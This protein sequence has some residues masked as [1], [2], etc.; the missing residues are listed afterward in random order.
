MTRVKV[1]PGPARAPRRVK[2]E[3]SGVAVMLTRLALG[4]CIAT[5][6]ARATMLETIRLPQ[7]ERWALQA[8]RTPGAATSLVLDLAC[9]IPAL[10]VLTRL[11]IDPG[12][13]L[14]RSW[15]YV[16]M[17]LL[18]GWL[19]LS[20]LWASD[21]FAA[22]VSAANFCAALVLLWSVSQ[23][24]RSWMHLRLVSAFAFALLVILVA[25]GIYYRVVDYPDLQAN[26][27][28]N[29][30]KYLE[31]RQLTPGSFPARR[32]EHMVVNSKVMAFSVSA[33][34]Y[35]ALI[36]MT[37]LISVGIALQRRAHGDSW[38]WVLPIILVIPAMFWMLLLAQSKAASAT[39]FLGMVLFAVVWRVGG[40]MIRFPRTFYV[41]TIAVLICGAGALVGYGLQHGRLFDDSLSFRWRYWV[42]SA[43]LFARHPITGVGWENFGENYLSVR[44]PIASEEIR[45]PHNFIV[46]FF[47][48]LGAMGGALMLLWMLRYWWE[49]T[50]TQ[51]KHEPAPILASALGAPPRPRS[52]NARA[53][54]LPASYEALGSGESSAALPAVA[55][56][57][58]GAVLLN[59]LSSIDFAQFDYALMEL[60]K[61]AVMFA[62]LVVAAGVAVVRSLRRQALDDRPAPLVL[63]A[64]LIALAMFLVH[65]LIDFSL[66]ELGAL[67]T[68]A[69][70]A[71]S[72]LGIRQQDRARTARNANK[73][74]LGLAAGVLLWLAVA[75]G[76]VR[77]VLVAEALAADADRDVTAG[78]FFEAA[79]K[80]RDAHSALGTNAD[81]LVRAA[82]AARM[83]DAPYEETRQ[84]V[85]AAVATDSMSTEALRLRTRLELAQPSPEAARVDR[86]FERLLTLDPYNVSTHLDY[87][88]ALRTFGKRDAARRQYEK[89]LQC[90]DLLLR[91]EPKRLA[92]EQVQAIRKSIDALKAERG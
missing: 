6:I 89:A 52:G 50:V 60:V 64:I 62:L 73:A 34:T 85:D 45:D 74:R 35:A 15:S 20:P 65:N 71:G 61:R 75:V 49:A 47:V 26:W 40:W 91:D 30:A 46:R 38:G 18:A 8:P 88:G 1:E 81:Y 86:D 17:A 43:R 36:V 7:F 66:F 42:A 63:H 27:S 51:G 24:V 37:T 55:S 2:A 4:I 10:L 39:L 59:V 28:R 77:P 48:E 78:R 53:S 9:C 21:R 90:D 83:A 76:F 41:V 87:A 68:F 25:Q 14:R 79:A 67:F 32:F 57:A 33:N 80:L 12:Y 31:E 92:P 5:S 56:I 44:L 69:L 84:I 23:L 58:A 13:A 72:A 54:S 11:A 19:I 3:A 16:P 29:S 22:S 70:F 82:R